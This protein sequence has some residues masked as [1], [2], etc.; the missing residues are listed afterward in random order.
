MFFL[1]F[2]KIFFGAI[3]IINLI[4]TFLVKTSNI[5]C[6][7]ILDFENFLLFLFQ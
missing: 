2:N 3:S 1:N 7:K 5:D 6:R 4:A